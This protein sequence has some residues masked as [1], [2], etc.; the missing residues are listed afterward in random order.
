MKSLASIFHV[1]I[2]FHPGHL[3]PKTLANSFSIVILLNCLRLHRVVLGIKRSQGSSSAVRLPITDSL[4]IVIFKSLDLQ[5]HD[6]CMFWAACNLAYFG[7]LRSAELSVPSLAAFSPSIHLAVS[8]VAVDSLTSPSCLR[9]T[10][11][12]SKTDPFRK[13]CS[14]HIGRGSGP[15]C[16]IHVRMVSPCRGISSSHG[17]GQSWHQ[18]GFLATFLVVVSESVLL[19][20]LPAMEFPIT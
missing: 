9:L 17:L 3:Q 2:R 20:L 7:F 1:A 8:D 19:P 11:K 18:Q 13:G 5:L 14:V 12:A 4:M 16:A 6:H 15:L 10:I